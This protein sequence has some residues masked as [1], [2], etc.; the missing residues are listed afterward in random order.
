MTKSRKYAII[1]P[2]LRKAVHKMEKLIEVYNKISSIVKELEMCGACEVKW[3]NTE[4]PPMKYITITQWYIMDMDS[5]TAI[6]C[7]KQIHSLVRILE[8]ENSY[9][10][11]YNGCTED[12]FREDKCC[13]NDDDVEDDEGA[14]IFSISIAPILL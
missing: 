12:V 11:T 5:T 13:E 10:R 1:Y 3:L 7:F 14:E 4:Y 6:Q 9:T 8:N 2:E